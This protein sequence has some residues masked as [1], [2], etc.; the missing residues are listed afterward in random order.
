MEEVSEESN[1]VEK[2]ES[3][4]LMQRICELMENQQLYLDSNLKLTDV[5]AMLGTNRNVVSVCINSKRNCSFSQ[6]VGEYRI[7]HAKNIMRREP[8]K[9]ISEVWMASGFSTETSFFR[10]FKSITGMTPNEYKMKND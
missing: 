1:V 6:F 8:G 9:K 4:E 5:A 7:A 2:S 10:T 3:Q